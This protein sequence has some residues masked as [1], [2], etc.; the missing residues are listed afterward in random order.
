MEVVGAVAAIWQLS[1]AAL[2]LS[3]TLYSLGSA[4]GSASEDVQILA[5]DLKTFAQSLTLLSRLL[6]DSKS[7]YSDDIYL[8]TA[9]IIK[10]CAALY[11]K[12]D[13]VLGK[14]G[15]NG[16]SSWKL[17]VKFV[18]KEGEIRKLL[19]RLRD[20][21]GTLATILM[22]LQVDLQLS[23]LNLSSTG[24]LSS[25]NSR[26]ASDV[27]LAPETLQNLREAQDSVKSRGFMSKYAV[28]SEKT[29]EPPKTSL[30][31]TS[32]EVH[33]SQ[34]SLAQS[35]MVPDTFDTQGIP[36]TKVSE[37]FSH[38]TM[39]ASRLPHSFMV[40][41][42]ENADM[43]TIFANRNI[44]QAGGSRMETSLPE[45]D[46][47]VRQL[48]AQAVASSSTDANTKTNVTSLFEDNPKR[49]ISTQDGGH[50][51]ARKIKAVQS[52][53]HAFRS[54]TEVLDTVL[55][56]RIKNRR[57]D[58]YNP[59]NLLRKSLLDGRE[60]IDSRNINH[61][62]L[63]GS[64][65]ISA[66]REKES[67]EIQRFG[68]ILMQDVGLKLHEYTA[69]HEE[70]GVSCFEPLVIS[71]DAI[72][73]QALLYLDMVAET[74]SAPNVEDNR[75]G[76]DEV[77]S[78]VPRP[79]RPLPDW[80]HANIQPDVYIPDAPVSGPRKRGRPSKKEIE[81]RSIDIASPVFSP[82]SPCYSPSSPLSPR[83]P[84]CQTGPTTSNDHPI[85]LG[86]INH[87]DRVLPPDPFSSSKDVPFVNLVSPSYNADTSSEGIPQDLDQVLSGDPWYPLFPQDDQVE[88]QTPQVEQA[89]L[90]PEEELAV[91]EHLGRRRSG[92]AISPPS[93]GVRKREKALPPIIV[94]DPNDTVAM[95]RARNTLAARKS[96]QRKMQRFKELEDEI[97]K[98]K[99]EPRT[100]EPKEKRRQEV[101][102]KK[103]KLWQ[104]RQAREGRGGTYNGSDTAIAFESA[105]KSHSAHSHSLASKSGPVSSCSISTSLSSQDISNGIASSSNMVHKLPPPEA[106]VGMS[107]PSRRSVTEL[108]ML[109]QQST[110]QNEVQKSQVTMVKSTTPP[111]VGSNHALQDYEM[112]LMLLEQQKKKRRMLDQ[113]EEIGDKGMVGR[114]SR[115]IRE[116]WLSSVPT[117][118]R[119]QESPAAAPPPRPP[120]HEL[121]NNKRD[122]LSKNEETADEAMTILLK[123]DPSRKFKSPVQTSEADKKALADY[124]MSLM[125]LNCR[126][127]P[128][129]KMMYRDE[130][131]TSGIPAAPM[132]VEIPHP[133]IPPRFD[134]ATHAA[135]ASAAKVPWA[136]Q[137]FQDTPHDTNAPLK[138]PKF[139][140]LETLASGTAGTT[141]E[142][143]LWST[144]HSQPA[145]LANDVLQ[146]FDFDSFLHQDEND[147]TFNFDPAI[148]SG[149][150]QAPADVSL[151]L[152]E[153][154][155]SDIS[156][157]VEEKPLYINAKQFHRVLK[158]RM[159]RHEFEKRNG[160]DKPG[161]STATPQSV[162]S[163]G[164]GLH[165]FKPTPL[166]PISSNGN[167]TEMTCSHPMLTS[168][169]TS[170]LWWQTYISLAS[171]APEQRLIF[172]ILS[173]ALRRELELLPNQ[174]ASD[175]EICKRVVDIF[176]PLGV[177]G[178]T[179]HEDRPELSGVLS[180]RGDIVRILMTV[181]GRLDLKTA[182]LGWSCV[183]VFLNIF[184]K[185]LNT[186]SPLCPSALSVIETTFSQLQEIVQI[187]ARYAVMENL[188][189]QSITSGTNS[190]L[191]LKPEYQST[192]LS[193]CTSI[194]EWFASSYGIGGIVTGVSNGEL[195]E[196]GALA[197]ELEKK[198]EGC[199]ALMGIIREKNSRCRIFRVEVDVSENEGDDDS[200]MADTDVED[201]SDGSWEEIGEDDMRSSVVDQ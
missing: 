121:Y 64:R 147:T 26:S 178:S 24:S 38:Q 98:L 69:E 111:P 185:V 195:K 188:Y 25:G 46:L 186:T 145:A 73:Q 200:D 149:E 176:K 182:T 47:T 100:L 65:Y 129:R 77:R 95:K 89:P 137:N 94:E 133:D 86:V 159:A 104:L 9:K 5:E 132:H 8:L 41:P 119:L 154:A 35:S 199:G 39:S 71:T 173:S 92:T 197:V 146:D 6:E 180:L 78:I 130:G 163:P 140:R 17:R 40:I 193:L 19:K 127:N 126:S 110:T 99:D 125:T 12:I 14:L 162:Y 18:Y 85:H 30:E 58:L 28:F 61:F 82:A 109:V 157:D 107:H 131:Y 88:K 169:Q 113:Q 96:R 36:K 34:Q 101:L 81:R 7:W 136:F 93:G 190:H 63:G 37:P 191:S 50:E 189:Q 152:P 49:A 3:K 15:G 23:L 177:A 187:I 135:K 80:Q 112:Q 57:L 179:L 29:V 70:L 105:Q 11:E 72:K 172:T 114:T 106:A 60:D 31:A 196:M 174:H 198:V 59:A 103:E 155:A 1:Q 118:V 175:E 161:G 165:P 33:N 68:S 142:T 128:K 183:C 141:I 10:D 138:H 184:N 158:R 52:V 115:V 117:K 27:S 83:G 67:L 76:H 164:P 84:N 87:H 20:M 62:K 42:S 120:V 16:K 74:A 45:A 124:Q 32:L 56:R 122:R 167:A 123:L 181:N 53:L 168:D 108:M 22:S 153:G 91:S 97:T 21:K 201:A 4:I 79:H 151:S 139:G 44:A 171:A 160:A 148:T 166:C 48:A 116:P 13:K 2:S 192:L 43:Q 55:E 143:H 102:A 134:P 66:F 144:S 194:L 75:T 90:L 51:I 54:A 156:V 150:D 170:R